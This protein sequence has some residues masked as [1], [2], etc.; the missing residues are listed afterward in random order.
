MASSRTFAGGFPRGHFV[1]RCRCCGLCIE[2]DLIGARW[3]HVESPVL[4]SPD[5]HSPAPRLTDKG[6]VDWESNHAR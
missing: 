5:G 4:I 6:W 3:T 2:F 1:A